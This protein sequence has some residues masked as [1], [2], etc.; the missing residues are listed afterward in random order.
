MQ[1]NILKDHF[2]VV[3]L[4]PSPSSECEA[5]VDLVLIQ[6]YFALLWKLP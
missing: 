6:A 2:T 3:G 5:Q 4:V 1:R